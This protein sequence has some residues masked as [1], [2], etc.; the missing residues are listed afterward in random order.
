MRAKRCIAMAFEKVGGGAQGLKGPGSV[1]PIRCISFPGKRKVVYAIAC[2]VLK[3]PF[4]F[5]LLRRRLGATINLTLS[6]MG[7]S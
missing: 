3:S 7:L 6:H 2:L 1:I 4:H 5:L